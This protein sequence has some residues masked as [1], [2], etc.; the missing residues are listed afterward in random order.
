MMR[1]QVPARAEHVIL[2]MR[3]RKDRAF[4][5]ESLRLTNAQEHLVHFGQRFRT[6]LR[7]GYRR[8][9]HFNIGDRKLLNTGPKVRLAVQ[10]LLQELAPSARLTPILTR[11]NEVIPRPSHRHVEQAQVFGVLSARQLRREL[12][13]PWRA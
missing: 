7:R 9:R 13:K 5:S 4:A 1:V 2:K 10:K 12:L 6:C 11:E 3:H 8:S